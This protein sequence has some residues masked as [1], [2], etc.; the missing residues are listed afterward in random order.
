[1]LATT[2]LWFLFFSVL[3][4]CSLAVFFCRS[5]VSSN[6]CLVL[7]HQAF[8][9]SF[10]VRELLFSSSAVPLTIRSG[11]EA[12]RPKNIRIQ[13]PTTG[14]DSNVSF[15]EHIVIVVNKCHICELA[16]SVT[17]SGGGADRG[18]DHWPR[19]VGPGGILRGILGQISLLPPAAAAPG[20]RRQV[21]HKSLCCGS[22]G[23]VSGSAGAVSGSAIRIQKGRNDPQT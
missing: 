14:E 18:V 17:C 10:E 23:A 5:R 21:G 8:K 1:M 22:A 16:D 2:W 19:E 3:V 15:V 7:C 9:L 12:G 4:S 11:S 6:F 13:I 20:G